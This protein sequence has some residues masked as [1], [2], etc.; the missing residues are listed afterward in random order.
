MKIIGYDTDISGAL[1]NHPVITNGRTVAA[2]Q[3]DSSG[4]KES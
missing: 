4:G 1:R 3:A 2:C